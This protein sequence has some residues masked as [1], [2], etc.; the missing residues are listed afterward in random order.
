MATA[1]QTLCG[2]GRELTHTDTNLPTACLQHP[3]LQ[4]ILDTFSS[5]PVGQGWQ[6]LS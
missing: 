6:I 2:P 3:P 5:F 4:P 1:C